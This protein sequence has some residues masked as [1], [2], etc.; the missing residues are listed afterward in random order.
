MDYTLNADS[1]AVG[2]Q[3]NS[4]N[5]S[6]PEQIT[7]TTT[8]ETEAGTY[9]NTLLVARQGDEFVLDF[10][11]ILPGA[12]SAR[13]ESRVFVSRDTLK[14]VMNTLSDAWAKANS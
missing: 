4:L 6:A 2:M 13:L 1:G 9:A 7:V 14:R 12:D 3:G 10:V 11:R 5:P 8:A